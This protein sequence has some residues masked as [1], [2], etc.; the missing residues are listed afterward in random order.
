M[1]M[2]F[3]KDSVLKEQSDLCLKIVNLRR[4]IHSEFYSTLP[5]YEQE[6][7]KSQLN[8]MQQYNYIL[9]QRIMNF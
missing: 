1:N 7:I 2:L 4:F 6:L 9:K 8:V 5:S 3:Y